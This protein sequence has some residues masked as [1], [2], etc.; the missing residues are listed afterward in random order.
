MNRELPT[1]EVLRFA[2]DYDPTTGAL[3]WTESRGR[4][5]KGTEAGSIQDKGGKKYLSVQIDGRRISAHRVAWAHFHGA[6][7]LGEIDH[8]DGDGRNN[9]IANLRQVTS[10]ENKQNLRSA[11]SHST[12]GLLGAYR[13]RTK[14]KAQIVI[15]GKC[16]HVGTF[17]TKE[18]AHAA[19]V[20]AKRLL[21]PMGTL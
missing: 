20:Q 6:W 18:E 2:L 17:E 13:W 19:Y 7:P 14:F 3:I 5:S 10:A 21:H 4:V 15:D 8:I 12:T 9:R 11:K 16:K 1:P